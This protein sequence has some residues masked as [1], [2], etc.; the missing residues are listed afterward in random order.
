MQSY[1]P[2]STKV[3]ICGTTSVHD[4]ELAV[5]LGAWALGM[6]FWERSPRRCSLAHAE[7]ISRA[8]RRR[9]QLCGVF[10]N[11]S[12]PRI[13][14]LAEE[15]HLAIVQLHGDEGPAF[16][17][18]VERRTGAKV[19]KA[20]QVGAAGDVRS[21]QRYHADYCLVDGH[22]AA[23]QRGGTGNTFDW[24]LLTQ[25]RPAR[26]GAGLTPLILSGGLT[27]ENVGEAIETVRPFAVDV[28][29]GVEAAPGRKDEERMRAFFEAVRA[30][31]APERAGEAA[32]ERAGEAAP[33][34]GAQALAPGAEARA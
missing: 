14:A 29:S 27:P 24:S 21:L 2:P 12:L 1:A 26:R 23:G 4:A 10:V 34:A 6:I 11:E 32:P 19:C 5:E 28:A 30:G 16:C 13:A 33:R 20:L 25:R 22:G 3:K 8:L 18:E 15:L 31:A 7:E 9:V 17:A